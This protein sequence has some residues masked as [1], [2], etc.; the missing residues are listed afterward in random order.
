VMIA[1]LEIADVLNDADAYWAEYRN[2]DS[3]ALKVPAI[4]AE[5]ADRL[6]R[7]GRAEEALTVLEAAKPC[8]DKGGVG[9]ETW[10]DARIAALESLGRQD[11][12]QA[13][14]WDFA[15]KAL[16]S[17]HLRDYLKRVPAFEDMVHEERALDLIAEHDDRHEALWFLLHWPE[18]HRAARLLLSAPKPLNGDLYMLLAPL[19]ELLEQLHPLA[20]TVCLR[21]MIDFTLSMARVRRYVHAAR[22]LATCHRLAVAITHWGEM[23]DHSSYLARLRQVHGRKRAFWSEVPTAVSDAVDRA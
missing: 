11:D 12:A 14:R 9:D 6:T 16:S 2:H 8:Q 22:H 23:S 1:M 15:L 19:A 21:S 10:C 4:A 13:L 17:R 18:P 5:V 7:A 20:A 3:E